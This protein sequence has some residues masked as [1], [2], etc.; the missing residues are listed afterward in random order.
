MVVITVFLETPMLYSLWLEPGPGAVRDCL[1]AIIAKSG[2]GPAFAPH[3]TLAGGV[4]LP[5]EAAAGAA[6]RTVAV[7]LP[8]TGVRVSLARVATGTTYHQ[9]VYALVEKTPMVSAAA[10]AARAAAAEHG[11]GG[12][13]GALPAGGAA[14]TTEAAAAAAYM[15]HVSLL[16]SDDAAARVSF[17]DACSRDLDL[18]ALS[19]DGLRVTAWRTG[20]AVE[21]WARVADVAVS[22]GEAVPA[23]PCALR[24]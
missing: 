24:L 17:A 4:S 13:E 8:A 20:G 15:P 19:F 11:D 12:G 9:C 22:G 7:R 1:T 6:A 14:T 23:R 10:A 16:Y 18:A 3:V 5:S 2:L 21:G